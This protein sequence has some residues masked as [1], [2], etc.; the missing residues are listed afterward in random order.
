MQ[1]DYVVLSNSKACVPNLG[2]I[3][4]CRW[5]VACRKTKKVGQSIA[6]IIRNRIA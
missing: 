6:S 2:Y 3:S 5:V 1:N 4:K